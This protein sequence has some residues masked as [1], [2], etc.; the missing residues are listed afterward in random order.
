[1]LCIF[2]SLRFFISW[3]WS[4]EPIWEL[5]NEIL[6][7]YFKKR[8]FPDIYENDIFCEKLYKVFWKKKV[9]VSKADEAISHYSAA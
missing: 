9:F 3:N 7:L 5:T 8:T 1:M 4:P 2:V 6:L